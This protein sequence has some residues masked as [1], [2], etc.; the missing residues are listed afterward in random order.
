VTAVLHGVRSAL[1]VSVLAVVMALLSG[2]QPVAVPTD[3]RGA[4]LA[5]DVTGGGDVYVALSLG[6]DRSRTDLLRIGRAVGAALLPQALTAT[7][8]ANGGGLPFVVLHGDGAFDPG[9]G[10]VIDWDSAAALDVLRRSGFTNI[11]MDLSTPVVPTSVEWNVPPSESYP[12][13]WYWD[14]LSSSDAAPAARLRLSPDPGRGVAGPALGLL[15]V[16][17][18]AF[19]LR[20]RC[21]VWGVAGGVAAT[22][23]FVVVLTTGGFM[24]ID[25]LA[26]RGLVS[27]PA[28]RVM[29]ALPVL[30]LPAAIVAWVLLGLTKADGGRRVSPG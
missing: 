12:A 16:A 20:R 25:N 24:Q 26:V 14:D 28:L 21:R 2:C 15:G 18:A 19:G 4:V 8:D 30:T 5:V 29:Y 3:P 6:G 7:V 23:A 27:G 9:S 22:A 11:S 13:R 10:P 1:R 17:L